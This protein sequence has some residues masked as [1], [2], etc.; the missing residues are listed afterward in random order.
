[1]PPKQPAKKKPDLVNDILAL[2]PKPPGFNPTLEM[3]KLLKKSKPD[4]VLQAANLAAAA[5]PDNAATPRF[6]WTDEMVECLLELRL[7]RFK[8]VFQGN[9]SNAQIGSY[10]TKIALLFNRSFPS[11]NTVD[12]QQLREKYGKL[13]V[14][15]LTLTAKLEGVH[16]VDCRGG[17]D[18]KR[19]SSCTSFLL[20]ASRLSLWR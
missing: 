10:W 12:S 18:R 4:L 14:M 16:N 19:R 5:N 15:P 11:T 7:G 20:A 1:M 13:K 6:K 9:K 2:I 3:V 8:D 17:R